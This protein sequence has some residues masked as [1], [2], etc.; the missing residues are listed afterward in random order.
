MEHRE[1]PIDELLDDPITRALM[2]V[3]RVERGYVEALLRA[4]RLDWH[5]HGDR[6]R[7]ANRAASRP[8]EA[9]PDRFRLSIG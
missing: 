9:C 8:P 2:A 4:K 7:R 3:D 1:P 6:E 5:R